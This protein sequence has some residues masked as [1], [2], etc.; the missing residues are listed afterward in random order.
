MISKK[1]NFAYQA[2]I[3]E[4]I[5]E[6]FPPNYIPICTSIF[7]DE[8]N[9]QS[10]CII[11]ECISVI[12]Y[13]IPSIEHYYNDKIN[14]PKITDILVSKTE[15]DVNKKY[16]IIIFLEDN[17]EIILKVINE[18]EPSNF[19]TKKNL[20]VLSKNSPTNWSSKALFIYF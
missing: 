12:N 20:V 13:F 5:H 6:Y 19:I 9:L 16:K 10:E 3:Q 8:I 4:T 14:C 15:L 18:D 1:P 2:V 11:N 17:A 7:Y